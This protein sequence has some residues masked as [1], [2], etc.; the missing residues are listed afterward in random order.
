MAFNLKLSP[1]VATLA[2]CAALT[3]FAQTTP[4][5]LNAVTVTGKAAPL[6]DV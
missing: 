4:G 2:V 5:R 6:L 3:S 1:L